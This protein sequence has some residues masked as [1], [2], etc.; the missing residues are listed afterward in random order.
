MYTDFYFKHFYD[1]EEYLVDDP[2]AVPVYT[3]QFCYNGSVNLFKYFFGNFV[4]N[5]DGKH[6][7]VNFIY[8]AIGCKL[9]AKVNVANSHPRPGSLSNDE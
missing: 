7:Y 4:G 2:D 5:V 1:L 6:E 9:L 8:I 3:Y